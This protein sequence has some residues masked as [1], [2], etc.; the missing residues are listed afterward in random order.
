MQDWEKREKNRIAVEREARFLERYGTWI[1]IA[2]TAA[3][4]FGVR[5]CLTPSEA[6]KQRRNCED[7]LYMVHKQLYGEYPSGSA[8]NRIIK[9]CKAL[10]ESHRDD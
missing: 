1:M 9:K 8:H 10:S 3:V 5:A 7:A 2:L 4:I 6:T